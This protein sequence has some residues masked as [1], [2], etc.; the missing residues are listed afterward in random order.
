[1]ADAP[2]HDWGAASVRIYPVLRPSGIAGLRVETLDPRALEAEGLKGHAQP[3][4]DEGPA[5]LSVVYALT[6]GGFDVIVNA[7]HLLSWGVTTADVQDAAVANLRAWSATAPW[8][9]ERSGPRRLVSSP[10]GDG[11]DASR[12]LLPEVRDRLAMDLGREVRIL[13]GLPE[14]HLLVAGALAAGDEEFAALLA[15]FVIESSGNA[16]EPIDRGLFELVA[17]SLVRFA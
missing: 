6:A 12:I 10:S 3:L 15:E 13:V 11:W 5:G 17:G 8:E 1:M 4:V 2:E 16:D 7:E 14:R 9:D